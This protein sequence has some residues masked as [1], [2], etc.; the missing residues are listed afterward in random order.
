MCWHALTKHYNYSVHVVVV[1]K[2]PKA[3]TTAATL[4][5]SCESPKKSS[6]KTTPL[7]KR[8]FG[9]VTYSILSSVENHFLRGPTDVE[10]ITG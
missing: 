2:P 8:K 5:R 10:G 9:T 6:Q 1:A 3:C 4:T 7:P